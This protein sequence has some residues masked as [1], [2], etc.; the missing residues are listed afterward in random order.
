MKRINILLILIFLGTAMG[1]RSGIFENTIIYISIGIILVALAF[2]TKN[3][4]IR[5]TLL[6]MSLILGYFFPILLFF[7]V[8]I[9]TFIVEGLDFSYYSV[10]AI[11]LIVSLIRVGYDHSIDLFIY[12]VTVLLIRILERSYIEIREKYDNYHDATRESQLELMATNKYLTESQ[13]HSIKIALLEER[14]RIARDIHDGVGHLISR[15]I[16]QTGAL[17]VTE[18]DDERRES[19][20]S[21]KESLSNSMDEIR[22]SVHNLVEE[23]SDLELLL[24]KVVNN[25]DFCEL[26]YSYEL[27]YRG[28]LNFNYS[29]LYIVQEALNNIMVH[30]NAT[31]AEIS[32][33]ET[34]DNIYLLIKDNGDNPKIDKLG[35]GLA[36]IRERINAMNG[37][38]EISTEKGFRIF[39][40]LGK[41]KL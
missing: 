5:V 3:L 38:I 32:L 1:L 31:E 26:R 19:L 29:I 10:M 36:S 7:S 40:T 12:T 27:K 18:R 2:Y 28:D 20:N 8:V 11:P 6:I 14:N 25:F 33:R 39:I 41:D 16:L 13:N 22:R 9:I 17:I 37:T 35:L 4:I 21:I 30:S 15:V 24:D 23:D 34:G